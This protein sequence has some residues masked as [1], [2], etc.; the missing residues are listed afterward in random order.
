MLGETH[1]LFWQVGIHEYGI[2]WKILKAVQARIE[3]E[4][5]AA[6]KT[7]KLESESQPEPVSLLIY[8]ASSPFF[9][10]RTCS[11]EETLFFVSIRFAYV[12][13][14]ADKERSRFARKVVPSSCNSTICQLVV[15]DNLVATW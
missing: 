3:E 15:S 7:R 10:K 2:R 11:R 14:D 6:D 13:S 5:K 8:N 12:I 1:L 9:T 4:N